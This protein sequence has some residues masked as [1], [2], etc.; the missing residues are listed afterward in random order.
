MKLFRIQLKII[1]FLFL[2][3]YCHTIRVVMDRGLDEIIASR[4]VCSSCQL[5]RE[6]SA[7]MR[8]NRGRGRDRRPPP[9]AAPRGP[10][11]DRE[12]YPREDTRKVMTAN[13]DEQCSEA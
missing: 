1:H 12:D 13:L 9:P 5:S 8:Q 4:S 2:D 7:N 11:R 3:N 6:Q 10:R